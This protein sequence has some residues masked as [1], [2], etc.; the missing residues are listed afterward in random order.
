MNGMSWQLEAGADGNVRVVVAGSI[1]EES[2]FTSLV[3]QRCDR[4]TMNLGSVDLI[5]SCG[6]REWI[7]FVRALAEANRP[8]EL[9]RC[10]PAIVRQLNMVANFKGKG[11][12]RSV[13]APYYCEPCRHEELRLVELAGG[14]P[15]DLDTEIPCP[16]CDKGMEFDDL[17][18][19][20]LAFLDDD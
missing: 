19:T 5:N 8:F 11:A 16:K 20:Y 14:R 9:V 10:A 12:V 18:E 6:V 1:T 13:L 4:L 3:A 15:S 17:P 2:D 7:R